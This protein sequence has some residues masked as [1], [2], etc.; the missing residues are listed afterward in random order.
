MKLRQKA[1]ILASSPA[2][3]LLAAAFSTIARLRLEESS[4]SASKTPNRERSEGIWVL[5]R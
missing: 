1:P 4:A 2:A 5:S 3:A